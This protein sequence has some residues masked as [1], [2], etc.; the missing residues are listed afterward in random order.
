MSISQTWP[1]TY[2]RIALITWRCRAWTW[3]VDTSSGQIEIFAGC[4]LTAL[5]VDHEMAILNLQALLDQ[6]A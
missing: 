4:A 6:Q 2:G 5:N 1:S 3:Y